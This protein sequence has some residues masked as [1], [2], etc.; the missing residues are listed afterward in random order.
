MFEAVKIF[1]LL[2]GLLLSENVSE[3][4]VDQNTCELLTLAEA[5]H[6]YADTEDEVYELVAVGFEESRF[7]VNRKKVVSHKGACGVYQQIPKYAHPTDVPRPT[8]EDLSDAWTSTFHAIHTFRKFKDIFK[9]NWICHYNSGYKCYESSDRYARRVKRKIK[10]LKNKKI[11]SNMISI[12]LR[13]LS[14]A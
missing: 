3:K 6:A 13:L 2:Q 4:V 11:A 1:L 14:C 5:I 8:C 9:E 12:K 7:S 10:L